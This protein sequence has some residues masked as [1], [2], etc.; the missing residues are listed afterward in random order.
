MILKLAE[1]TKWR[2]QKCQNQFR[3]SPTEAQGSP[4]F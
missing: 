3:L 2:S 1:Q 4:I